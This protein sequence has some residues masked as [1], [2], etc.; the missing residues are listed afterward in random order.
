MC[1]QKKLQKTWQNPL[2]ITSA[3]VLAYLSILP[4]AMIW[5]L[6]VDTTCS[7]YIILLTYNILKR[8]KRKTIFFL[9]WFLCVS[10]L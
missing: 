4:R 3:I 8:E 2:Y 5:F 7:T 6:T 1:W 9:F 10:L